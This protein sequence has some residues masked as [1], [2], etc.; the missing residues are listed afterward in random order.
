[1]SDES[2]KNKAVGKRGVWG[3]NLEGRAEKKTE[4]KGG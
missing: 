2:L 1:M 4:K 3:K